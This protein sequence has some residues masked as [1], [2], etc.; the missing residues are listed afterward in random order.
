[1]R[2]NGESDSGTWSGEPQRESDCEPGNR[3]HFDANPGAVRAAR[4]RDKAVEERNVPP[5]TQARAQNPREARMFDSRRFRMNRGVDRGCRRGAQR[6]CVCVRLQRGGLRDRCEWRGTARRS[7]S[8]A[9]SAGGGRSRLRRGRGDDVRLSR[10][11]RGSGSVRGSAID[12]GCCRRCGRTVGRASPGSARRHR[13]R[14]GFE[15]KQDHARR[16]GPN[17]H[18]GLHTCAIRT[19]THDQMF[20]GKDTP[21]DRRNSNRSAINRNRSAAGVTVDDELALARITLSARSTGHCKKAHAQSDPNERSQVGS[22]NGCHRACQSKLTEVLQAHRLVNAF[23][24]SGRA[25]G[26]CGTCAQR[27]ESIE[28][29]ARTL[30]STAVFAPR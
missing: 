25:V 22:R 29:G 2:L 18:D 12:S 14:G 23:R 16:S 9:R 7:G 1:M 10:R 20:A 21:G 3:V 8:T 11:R 4:L 15:A 6:S 13:R 5:G 17:L 19:G 24:A 26:V 27:G 28:C 30:A